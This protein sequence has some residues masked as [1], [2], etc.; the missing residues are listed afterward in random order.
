MHKIIITEHP[1]HFFENG[2][3]FIATAY[4]ENNSHEIVWNIP[5][6]LI[7]DFT[8]FANANEIKNIS[9]EKYLIKHREWFEQNIGAEKNSVQITISAN[10]TSK[11]IVH[12]T[13]SNLLYNQTD[14]IDN[15]KSNLLSENFIDLEQKSVAYI[16][17][18]TIVSIAFDNKNGSITVLT[19]PDFRNKGYATKCLQK[20]IEVYSGDELGFGTDIENKAAIRVAEKCGMKKIGT[21]FWIRLDSEHGKELFS[22]KPELFV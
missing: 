9:D 20:L 5:S 2:E 22:Q 4:M 21:G 14:H 16:I 12:I 13:D 19:L 18:N 10:Y 6:A 8:L 1:S 15:I 17:D 3:V 11:E 7:D